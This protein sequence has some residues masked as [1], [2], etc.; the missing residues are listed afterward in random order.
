MLF[1]LLVLAVG[2]GTVMYLC[3]RV[4]RLAVRHGTEDAWRPRDLQATHQRG[5]DPARE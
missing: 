5:R 1:L 3:Y 4:F 2:A